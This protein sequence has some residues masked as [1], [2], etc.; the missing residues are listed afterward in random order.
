MSGN[1]PQIVTPPSKPE[2]QK[3]PFFWRNISILLIGMATGILFAA[4]ILVSYAF[5]GV[6]HGFAIALNQL[7]NRLDQS[8]HI[9]AEANNSTAKFEQFMRETDETLKT[10][11]QEIADIQKEQRTNKNDFLIA[12]TFHLVKLAND[13]LQYENNVPLA[14]KMI[15]SADQDMAKLTDPK[16]Y[17]V[18]EALA[19]DLVSLQGA[20]QVDVAGIYARLSALSDQ[21]PKLSLI[22]QLLNHP[23][24]AMVTTENLPWWRRGL[25]SM[26]QALQRIV[27]VR[28]NL[29]N[30]PPFIAPDQ[31]VYLFQNLQAQL[32]KAQWGL[33][34]HQPDIYRT[35]LLQAA[36]WIK[37]FSVPDS[38][39]AKQ[40]LQSLGQLQ[41]INIRP[42]VPNLTSSMRA[43]ENYMNT[44]A[45]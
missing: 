14:I 5:L 26:E 35:S 23:V 4:M 36:N 29:P 45:K 1:D 17:L 21:I 28:Q 25:N 10:Q 9:L 6:N 7:T 16:S 22:S 30:A 12:E 15:Q 2:R 11:S 34:H 19:A 42:S 18:R 44:A 37:Q 39:V 32:E 38:V 41:E 13:S 43:I 20:T 3:S 8:Q 24:E 33:L 40:L 31:Q 27:I